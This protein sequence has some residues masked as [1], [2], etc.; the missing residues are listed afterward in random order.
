MSIYFF[1]LFYF[2]FPFSILIST[3]FD[4]YGFERFRLWICVYAWPHWFNICWK[5]ISMQLHNLS[6]FTV[7][8]RIH[9]F[10]RYTNIKV[11]YIAFRVTLNYFFSSP[12]KQWTCLWQRKKRRKTH[13]TIGWWKH[14]KIKRFREK[15]K[16]KQKRKRMWKKWIF[17]F[18]L[19]IYQEIKSSDHNLFC[20]CP[21]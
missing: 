19:F 3:L 2:L 21:H 14:E 5:C 13:W 17:F 20:L 4:G 10:R 16:L 15:K 8:I 18:F 11:S 7:V 12:Q 6:T 9:R 1:S